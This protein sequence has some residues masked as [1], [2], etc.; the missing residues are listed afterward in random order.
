MSFAGWGLVWEKANY[1]RILSPLFSC[2]IKQI[3]SLVS[4]TKCKKLQARLGAA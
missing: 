1:P 2:L 4:K 3:C